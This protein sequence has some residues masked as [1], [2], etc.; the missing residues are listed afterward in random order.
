MATTAVAQTN[1]GGLVEILNAAMP[2]MKRLAP[3][4][5]NLQRLTALA[6]EAKMRSPMLAN[7][8]AVSVV[9]FCKKCAEMGTDRVGAGGM[10]PVPFKNGDRYDMVPMPDWRLLVERCKKAKCITHATAECVYEADLFEMERG[11]EPK[12]KHVPALKDRGE[13]LGAYCVYLLPDGTKDF[14]WMP[15]S[16]VSHIRGKSKAANNGPWVSDFG[17]M[18]KKTVVRRALKVFEGASPELTRLIEIDNEAVGYVSDEP[19]RPSIAM[20]VEKGPVIDA[21]A[22]EKAAPSAAAASP[23]PH[24]AAAPAPTGEAT[25]PPAADAPPA[26][27]PAPSAAPTGQQV[28]GLVLSTA[29]KQTKKEGVFRYGIKVGDAWY[30]TFDDAVSG[31]AERAR[32]E[33]LRVRIGF[34]VSKFGNDITTFAV[35]ERD[36]KLTYAGGRKEGELL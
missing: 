1:A 5:V 33:G 13:L 20:P 8:S 35:E 4:Y 24:P 17:E 12:L 26:G 18:A 22:T 30:N 28:D 9:N 14:S 34:A 31:A 29:S 36:G 2:D 23:A 3:K 21:E 32:H 7:C 19:L 10:W 25:P 27:E 15:V 6:I 11:L 16:E